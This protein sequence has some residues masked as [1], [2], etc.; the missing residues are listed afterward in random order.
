MSDQLLA[1]IL[2]LAIFLFLVAWVPF[3]DLLQRV[4]RKYRETTVA[5]P[6][7]L[8]TSRR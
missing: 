7:R 8:R 4:I 6:T 3:L 1:L 5:A 2:T